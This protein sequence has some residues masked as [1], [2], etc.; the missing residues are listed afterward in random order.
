MLKRTRRE[1]MEEKH[2]K[3][4]IGSR[5][6]FYILCSCTSKTSDF[7]LLSS[8]ETAVHALQVLWNE[9]VFYF[10]FSLMITTN[11]SAFNYLVNSV[12][13]LKE[14]MLGGASKIY[15]KSRSDENPN[16]R[17][18]KKN[19]KY[20]NFCFQLCPFPYESLHIVGAAVVYARVCV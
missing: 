10:F 12:K 11:A 16:R 8:S 17:V 4:T 6:N 18:T 19:E 2:P 14:A 5:L 1:G 3:P 7:S 20:Q 13:I 15:L 9:I